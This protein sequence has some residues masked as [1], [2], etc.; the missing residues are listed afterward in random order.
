MA[1]PIVISLLAH[2]VL[3][4][5][6]FTSGSGIRQDQH[7][8]TVNIRLMRTSAGTEAGRTRSAAHS[9]EAGMREIPTRGEI[10]QPRFEET[11]WMVD[12]AR[13]GALEET[14]KETLK[15]TLKRTAAE[16]VP[17]PGKNHQNH[18][19]IRKADNS[20]PVPPPLSDAAAPAA[21]D[22]LSGLESALPVDL[23]TRP[24]VSERWALRWADGAQRGI[25]KSPSIRS[26]AVPVSGERLADVKVVI[27]VSA[28][29]EVVSAEIAPPGS[30]DI[31]IDR[32]IAGKAF[33][34]AFEETPD[35]SGNQTAFFQ[36]VFDGGAR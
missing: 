15:E 33:D 29:G 14:V 26:D 6:L 24:A 28:Q 27:V 16:T 23:P 5:F 36:L 4:V 17:G 35:D 21:L 8:G 11:D 34:F 19:K 32:Y 20:P 22:P 13:G 9:P 7:S 30:G 3:I 1:R 25:I 31:R 10:P 12:W 2:L 18:Q